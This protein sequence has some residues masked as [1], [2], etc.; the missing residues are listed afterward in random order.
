M[1]K[2]AMHRVHM[3]IRGCG[4]VSSGHDRERSQQIQLARVVSR[5]HFASEGYMCCRIELST[6][7]KW[8]HQLFT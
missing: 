8:Y 3:V 2:K 4:M 5:M 1:S 6:P 7:I